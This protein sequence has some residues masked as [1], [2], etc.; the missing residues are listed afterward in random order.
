MKIWGRY[1]TESAA[2]S[3]VGQIRWDCEN[4][5]ENVRDERRAAVVHYDSMA[6]FAH[7]A[8]DVGNGVSS[9]ILP[10]SWG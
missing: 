4:V 7:D 8:F 3:Q 2:K 9:R 1:R 5:V 6:K 10:C